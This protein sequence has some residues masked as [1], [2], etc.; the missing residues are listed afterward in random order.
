MGEALGPLF[1]PK[2]QFHLLW[3]LGLAAAAGAIGI[4]LYAL[5]RGRLSARLGLAGLGVLP[6]FVLL[7]ADLDMLD[8]S[9]ELRFCGSCHEP[10]APL[11]ASLQ[12]VNGS[13]AS[14]HYQSGAIKG[15][16]ACYTCHSGYGLLGDVAAKRA[17]L[18]HMWHE[19]RGSYEYPLAMKGPFDID[20][21]LDC[22]RHAPK[23]RAVAFHTDPETQARLVAR[24]LSCTG[25]CHPSAHPAESLNGS[26][27]R[28][29]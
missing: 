7:I 2:P 29:R 15:D 25:T 19:L 16:T 13:L 10:M 17:G 1:V 12:E 4:A 27:T 6:G 28:K 9:K 24:E 23:F 21:C 22:H 3:I 8:R 26:G 5:I 18:S 11:V 20:A 14:I